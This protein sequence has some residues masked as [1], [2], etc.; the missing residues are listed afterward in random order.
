MKHGVGIGSFSSQ[1]FETSFNCQHSVD[2]HK[3][4]TVLEKT[5]A[6][7]DKVKTFIFYFQLILSRM[8][9]K[10]GLRRLNNRGGVVSHGGIPHEH[11]E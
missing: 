9:L 8:A 6:R 7:L 11:R 5:V 3:S 2:G 10:R 1:R 4:S